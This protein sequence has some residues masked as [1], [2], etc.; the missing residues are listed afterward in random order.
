MSDA[1]SS[2]GQSPAELQTR[3][4]PCGSWVTGLRQ[5]SLGGSM[6]ISLVQRSLESVLV[7]ARTELIFSI[8]AGVGLWFGF[9]LET[10]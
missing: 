7:L 9:V 3:R 2:R 10:G 4:W 1:G 6:G 8:A 5:P